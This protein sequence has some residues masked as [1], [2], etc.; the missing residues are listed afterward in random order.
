MRYNP[1][2]FAKVGAPV[3]SPVQSGGY[4]QVN[5]NAV[6]SAA[7]WP[8]VRQTPLAPVPITPPA[9]P[10]SPF[11]GSGSSDFT[12]K[13]PYGG[14]TGNGYHHDTGWWNGRQVSDRQNPVTRIDGEVVPLPPKA[15]QGNM[16][17][18]PI[19]LEPGRGGTSQDNPN[20]GGT[21]VSAGNTAL[22]SA[23]SGSGKLASSTT[24][25]RGL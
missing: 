3:T 12:I 7:A 1:S 9:V 18:R 11:T 2:Q 4:L 15:L 23:G 22:G 17:R 24:G 5:P 20:P 21:S 19:I 6:S 25:L 13:N 10:G 14:S 8:N 16:P